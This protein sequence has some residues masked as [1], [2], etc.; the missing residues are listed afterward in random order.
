[1]RITAITQDQ[2]IVIDGVPAFLGQM[3]G[4]AM[5]QGEW[6]IDYNTL[7]GLGHIEYTDNRPNQTI[8][9]AV[10]DAAY[11]WLIDEH[12]RYVAAIAEQEAAEEAARNEQQQDPIDT[13]F[14]STGDGNHDVL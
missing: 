10:F 2:L 3:G 14:D 7:T 5:R 9:S 6:A 1:M 13:E 8:N 4:F 11:A 12:T